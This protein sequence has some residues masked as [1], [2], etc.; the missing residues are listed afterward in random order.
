MKQAINKRKNMN[1]IQL[2]MIEKVAVKV[3]YQKNL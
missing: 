2:T 1:K 3:F